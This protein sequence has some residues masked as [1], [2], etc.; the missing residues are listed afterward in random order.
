M[1]GAAGV[2]SG[3]AVRA[4]EAATEVLRDR[5][6]RSAYPAQDGLLPE[7]LRRPALCR[8]GLELRMALVACVVLPTTAELDRDDIGGSPPMHATRLFVDEAPK[9]QGHGLWDSIDAQMSNGIKML[10]E[11]ALRV[12]DL[13]KMK[14]FYRDVLG[15]QVFSEQ[16][17]GFVFLTVAEATEGHPQIIGLFDRSVAIAQERTTLDHLAFLID[18]ADYETQKQRLEALGVAVHPKLFP[19]FHWRSLFFEDPE[20]NTVEL[21]CYDGSV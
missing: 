20:G 15:L 9:C 8:M 14:T 1:A 19:H 2:E 5:Q 4:G 17:E 13:E 12:N 18:L 16:H 3:P 7:L 11:L 10:G 21:V 6:L